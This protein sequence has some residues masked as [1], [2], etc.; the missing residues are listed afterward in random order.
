ME[1]NWCG[2]F[3]VNDFRGLLSQIIE[4]RTYKGFHFSSTSDLDP[5]KIEQFK[6]VVYHVVMYI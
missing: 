6:F 5:V 1:L 4:S 2:S 3:W